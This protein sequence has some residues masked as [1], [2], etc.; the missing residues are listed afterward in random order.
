LAYHIGLPIH[1][2]D[3]LDEMSK[4][5]YEHSGGTLDGFVLSIDGLSVLTCQTYANHIFYL[6]DWIS[7]ERAFRCFIRSNKIM[8]GKLPA[9]IT[10]LFLGNHHCVLTV[11]PI[12]QP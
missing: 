3:K 6:L 8:V 10:I 11:T 9:S 1:D 4:G 5:F 7:H 2:T 12:I